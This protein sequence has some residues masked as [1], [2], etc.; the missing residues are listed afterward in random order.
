MSRC[1]CSVR[2][3]ETFV[4]D[5]AGLDLRTNPS[6]L[7]QRHRRSRY[8]STRSTLRIRQSPSQ[9]FEPA[10][11]T[12]VNPLD[13]AYIPFDF[14]LPRS[15]N[16]IPPLS[17]PVLPP[18]VPD[19]HFQDLEEFEPELEIAEDA[20][21]ADVVSETNTAPLEQLD[22]V[23][24][25]E[26]EEQV[27]MT[28]ATATTVDQVSLRSLTVE[29]LE[30]VSDVPLRKGLSVV[31]PAKS[32]VQSRLERKE[33]RM[34][35]RKRAQEEEEVQLRAQ[36]ITAALKSE[37]AKLS[38]KNVARVTSNS[39]TE[40]KSQEVAATP[41]S[42]EEEVHGILAA[43]AAARAKSARK[44]TAT[45]SSR[46]AKPKTEKRATKT[47]SAGTEDQSQADGSKKSE[48]EEWQIQ[49]AALEG[50]FG[51]ESWNPRK[52]ISPDALAGIRAL[53]ASQPTVY[54]TPV[55]AEHFKVSP[56]AIRR[57]LKSKW[58]PKEEE[59]EDRRRRWEKRGEKKWSEMVELGIRPPKKWR[60]M[61]VGKVGKG[62]AP[63]WKRKDT[64]KQGERW[65][66]HPSTVAF[67]QA[68]DAPTE[69][70]AW[71]DDIGSR[72]L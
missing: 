17:E 61:G 66:E 63:T 67:L 64:R 33:R 6:R 5:V 4:R 40:E 27:S 8:F 60:E 13:D 30:T 19:E 52:R 1:T 72:I 14:N 34:E 20:A 22:P 46:A 35:A 7:L 54:T 71:E 25:V 65:I 51:E 53:H 48:R 18:S 49:K 57:I 10:L 24:N 59:V 55:L 47:Q 12:T 15:N 3:L 42:E 28:S 41:K 9:H 37:N 43:V 16:S 31:V 21:I 38:K 23:T 26:G 2:A 58:Q 32:R 11:S 62:E 50:K 39:K 56:E 44:D 45:Q 69:D 29:D 70:V 36:V 68:G